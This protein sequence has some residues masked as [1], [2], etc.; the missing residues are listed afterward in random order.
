VNK[1]RSSK[2][3]MPSEQT[4]NAIDHCR[5]EFARTRGVCRNSIDQLFANN[6]DDPYAAFRVHFQ[7]VCITR[8]A[9]PDAYLNDL[10]SIKQQC[11]PAKHTEVVE[12]FVESLG[13]AHELI[14]SGF[15][16]LADGKLDKYETRELIGLVSKTRDTL[17]DLHKSLTEKDCDLR[18]FAREAVNGRK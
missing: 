1:I 10:L 15:T 4:I 6:T 13:T 14:K 17:E 3:Y 2:S 16:A 8:E 12:A 7:F 5:K 9:N 11:R 18:E